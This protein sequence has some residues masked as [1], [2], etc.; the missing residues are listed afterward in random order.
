MRQAIVFTVALALLAAGCDRK[1]STEPPSDRQQVPAATAAAGGEAG[2][3]P[4]AERVAVLGLLNKRN[5]IVRD[6]ALRPGQS[7]RVKDAVVRLRACETTAPWENEAL[8]GAFVQLDVELPDGRWQRVFSGWLYK[9]SPSLNVV[10]HPVY[11]VAPK[12]C[13]MTYPAGRA[14]PAVPVASNNR[15]SARKSGGAPAPREPSTGARPE[16]ADDA[17]PTPAEPPPSAADN[18][19]T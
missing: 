14:A 11:D 15:S 17:A 7:V 16:P 13:A 6:I 5:G 10:E 8:T 12:S 9:E 2:V 3:T 4:M 19:A 18:N 1:R